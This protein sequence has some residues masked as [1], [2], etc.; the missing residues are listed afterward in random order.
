MEKAYLDC[1]L[2][3]EL[4]K[5]KVGTLRRSGFVPGVVYGKGKSPLAIQL[6]QSQLIK[7][8]HAH[9]GGENMIISLRIAGEKETSKA[10]KE[11]RSVL[12]KDIQYEPVH[13][14][15]LHVDF[16]E[17]SLTE[18]IKVKVPV[19]PVGESEGVKKENGVFTHVLWELEVECLPMDI[20]EKITFNV[21]KMK[22]GDAVYVKD[23]V[24]P[25]EVNLLTDKEAIVFTLAAPWK[26]VEP[27]AEEAAVAGEKEAA[28][29]EVI[30]KEKKE[31]EEEP[32]EEKAGEK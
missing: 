22:I 16:N 27:T 20:P 21:E 23:L 25:A 24:L 29:P 11:E 28:E 4:G 7:F 26:I 18:K 15:I 30:K 6:N 19:E 9:H 31:K 13:D 2:R 17:I 5:N 1:N 14:D 12:I 8:M 3:A 32:G 10:K